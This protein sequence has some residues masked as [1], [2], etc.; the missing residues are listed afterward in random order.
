M[1]TCRCHYCVVLSFFHTADPVCERTFRFLVKRKHARS[2]TLESADG[3]VEETLTVRN[4]DDRRDDHWLTT[5]RCDSDML[6]LQASLNWSR[7]SLGSEWAAAAADDDDDGVHT[8][9][10]RRR[11]NILSMQLICPV[12]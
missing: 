1:F 8:K 12:T 3:T 11:G 7:A 9:P 10:S 2:L 5:G 6:L 4:D